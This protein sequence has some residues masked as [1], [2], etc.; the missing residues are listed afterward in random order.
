MT[1]FERDLLGLCAAVELDPS[2]AAA[3]ADAHGDQ[4]RPF[5]SFAL[6]VAQLDEPHWSA[7]SPGRPLRHWR[8]LEVDARPTLIT[9]RLAIDERILHHLLGVHHLD[10]R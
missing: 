3:C 2:L 8:L 4:S 7:L 9:G 5:A 1:T 10:P 6:A